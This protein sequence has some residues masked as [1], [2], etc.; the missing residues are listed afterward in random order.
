M[1]RQ[2]R[3]FLELTFEVFSKLP[4][5][6][7]QIRV[8]VASQLPHPVLIITTAFRL[9][10]VKFTVKM[11]QPVNLS[12]FGSY[13]IYKYVY[14]CV[15]ANICT[16]CSS[17]LNLGF[18]LKAIAETSFIHTSYIY[19]GQAI[20]AELHTQETSGI[21]GHVICIFRPR[22]TPTTRVIHVINITK[23]LI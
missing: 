1:F 11:G 21:Q 9:F 14:V 20:A 3:L 18:G 7:V 10:A 8:H 22:T 13:Y 2:S 5:D 16:V 19:P 6:R 12:V 23:K 4:A 17:H 15:V